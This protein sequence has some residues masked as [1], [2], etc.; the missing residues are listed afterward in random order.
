MDASVSLLQGEA[1]AYADMLMAAEC[2][3]EAAV[4]KL[5]EHLNVAVAELMEQQW[6]LWSHEESL[7]YPAEELNTLRH[8]LLQTAR[9]LQIEIEQRLWKEAART[10]T[11]HV[12]PSESVGNEGHSPSFDEYRQR[13]DA[14]IKWAKTL[15]K[16]SENSFTTKEKFAEFATVDRADLY[17]WQRNELP[18]TSAM[19]EKIEA[20][21]R[22][23]PQPQRRD[24]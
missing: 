7:D 21:I 12:H 5:R 1:Y 8:M 14:H 23:L 20:A 9:R 22:R 6:I 16:P 10:N 24:R 11:C 4:T 17:R 15:T 13:L 2:A 19:R 3:T 18:T